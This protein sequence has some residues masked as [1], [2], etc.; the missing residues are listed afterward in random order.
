MQYTS[1]V[2]EKKGEKIKYMDR[3]ISMVEWSD[4]SLIRMQKICKQA[5][6]QT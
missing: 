6:M 3:N 5:I 4:P 1:S 2:V